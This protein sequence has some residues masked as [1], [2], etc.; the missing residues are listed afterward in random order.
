MEER[1]VRF[2]RGLARS[3]EVSA[4][5]CEASARPCE[6]SARCCEV[7]RG[8]CKIWRGKGGGLCAI[9]TGREARKHAG[10]TKPGLTG[11]NLLTHESC[12]NSRLSS[13][14]GTVG[15]PGCSR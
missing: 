11:P 9:E 13:G 5:S 3:C 15:P 2:L 4:R 1:Y 12:R 14:C 7:L 10:R 8:L 6:A